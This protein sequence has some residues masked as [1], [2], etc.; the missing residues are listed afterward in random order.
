MTKNHFNC[1]H[2]NHQII[3]S[4][5]DMIP[6]IAQPAQ[7]AWQPFSAFHSLAQGPNGT[8][9]HVDPAGTWQK[10]TPISRLQPKDVATSLLDAGIS[11]LLVTTGAGLI[12]WYAELP[13]VAGPVM[14]LAAA[15]ARYFFGMASARELLRIVETWSSAGRDSSTEKPPEKKQHVVTLEV[16]EGKAWKFAYLG[17]DPQK[18]ISFSEAVLAG[19]AFTE[20]EAAEHGLTQDELKA[21]RTEFLNQ[22]WL[23]WNHPSRPQQGVSLRIAG[24]KVLRA[25]TT[26][27]LPEAD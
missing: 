6:D 26:T 20:R 18:L 3:V 21:L 13:A 15:A 23:V 12:C 14:G 8:E 11:F 1:P 19:R 5:S 9:V 2:C 10:V 7:T 17:I 25:I 24:Q 22:N 27:P 4:L 16:K